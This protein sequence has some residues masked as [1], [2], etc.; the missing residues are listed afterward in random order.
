MAPFQ[1]KVAAIDRA[2][3]CDPLFCR[4]WKR[5]CSACFQ[6][7]ILCHE[8]PIK[9]YNCLTHIQ[10]VG[11]RIVVIENFG[12]EALLYRS[13]VSTPDGVPKVK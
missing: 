10:E 1:I 3:P 8:I 4:L 7:T 6:Y 9:W 11:E 12:E 13:G 2:A 5:L